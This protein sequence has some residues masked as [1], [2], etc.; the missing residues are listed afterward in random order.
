MQG[1]KQSVNIWPALAII[2][3]H[4]RDEKL[5]RTLI[6]FQKCLYI[7]IVYDA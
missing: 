4:S 7:I 6:T 3:G 2:V 1:V 5:V